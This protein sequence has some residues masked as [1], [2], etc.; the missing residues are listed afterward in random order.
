MSRET[1]RSRPAPHPGV[2]DPEAG[3]WCGTPYWGPGS[4]AHIRLPEPRAW[5]RQRQRELKGHQIIGEDFEWD[6]VH[7]S[8]LTQHRIV[9]EVKLPLKYL[10][11][12][13]A[14]L[15]ETESSQH[16]GAADAPHAPRRCQEPG[17]GSPPPPA[18]A[19]ERGLAGGGRKTAWAGGGCVCGDPAWTTDIVTNK[20]VYKVSAFNTIYKN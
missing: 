4:C 14:N 13:I 8:D 17:E 10:K 20:T 11:S 15:E 2:R 5:S 16:A 12:L 18:P 19:N 3:A 7:P 6:R 1:Q 9:D